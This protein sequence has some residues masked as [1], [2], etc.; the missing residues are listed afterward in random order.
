[1]GRA[2]VGGGGALAHSHHTIV[3]PA[4]GDTVQAFYGN[5]LGWKSA[6]ATQANVVTGGASNHPDSAWWERDRRSGDTNDVTIITNVNTTGVNI[7]AI[8]NL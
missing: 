2:I 8:R 5:N 1:M 3:T 6:L 7:S 4:F